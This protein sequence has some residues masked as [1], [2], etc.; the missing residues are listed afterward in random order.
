MQLVGSFQAEVR[1]EKDGVSVGGTS[2]MGLMMLAASP[3]CLHP[4]DRR[5]RRGGGGDGGAGGADR[6]ALRRRDLSARFNICT[7]KH[8]F[9]SYCRRRA[10]LLVRRRI[11]AGISAARLAGLSARNK[12]QQE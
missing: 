6:V 2:I 11:R 4:R 5:R 9:M 12:D 3:G 1:V 8:F 7:H 10:D